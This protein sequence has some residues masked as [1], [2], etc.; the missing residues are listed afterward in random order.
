MDGLFG[1]VRR[2]QTA[3]A[4][5][6]NWHNRDV[7]RS[8]AL[9]LG[10]TVAAVGAP[11]LAST[12]HDARHSLESADQV[13]YVEGRVTNDSGAGIAG[14]VGVRPYP[15]DVTLYQ[16]ADYAETRPD[17]SY[18]LLISTPGSYWLRFESA[19]PGYMSV[20]W[21]GELDYENAG[22]FVTH[23]GETTVVDQVLPDGAQITG[24][25]TDTDGD[26]LAHVQVYVDGVVRGQWTRL[27]EDWTESEAPD[28]G[29]YVVGGLPAG[30]YRLR[31]G[32]TSP[33]LTE[34]WNDEPQ[35]RTLIRSPSPAVRPPPARTPC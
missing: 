25:V 18:R 11:A 23:A 15:G 20:Y 31:F 5:R 28:R 24:R 7:K 27:D 9:V 4:R 30:T 34:W 19:V 21:P 29:R 22:V 16:Q 26:P 17:G 2:R 12:E 3:F 10:F 14:V 33:Y 32:P 6:D 35:S 13:S 1:A 8:A